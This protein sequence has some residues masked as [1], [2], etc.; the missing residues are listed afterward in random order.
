M[1]DT[2][3]E[4][5]ISNIDCS[6]YFI[7]ILPASGGWNIQARLERE[8]VV[9]GE[10]GTG[11]GGKLYVSP[12]STTSEVVQKCL[13]AVLAF[14]EHEVRETF[15]WKGRA[16]FHPHYNVDELWAICDR[17]DIRE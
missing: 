5:I 15:K 14:S 1:N 8:D 12:H 16:V 13:G 11:S 2:D 17:T 4:E 7:R 6:P 10:W 9:T 3:L